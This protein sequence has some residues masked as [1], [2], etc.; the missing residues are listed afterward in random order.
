[1][2]L[3]DILPTPENSE[4]G[5]LVVLTGEFAEH[6]RASRRSFF[7]DRNL[8]LGEALNHFVESF[9]TM[10][11]H[12][13]RTSA[14]AGSFER[15]F[16]IA[17]WPEQTPA[18]AHGPQLVPKIALLASELDTLLRQQRPKLLIFLSC[19]L[20][21]AMNEAQSAFLGSAGRPLDAGRRITEERL[22]AYIQHWE[23]LTVLALPIPS[24]NTTER[25]FRS[26]APGVQR[27]FKETELLP[28]ATLDPLLGRA[29]SALVLDRAASLLSIRSKLHVDEKRAEE[30]FDA[31]EGR[32]YRTD[33][34]G[35]PVV[36]GPEG[37]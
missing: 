36:L 15:R 27:A 2:L 35:R 25:F 1:M 14:T 8:D 22:A 17:T 37:D 7:G 33:T 32:A 6:P 23:H 20:W 18:G 30:L 12:L 21:R 34:A 31:L 5:I 11:I 13:A 28:E 9:E 29:Q 19:Y 4:N 24:K 3:P 26:I 10:G 16:C